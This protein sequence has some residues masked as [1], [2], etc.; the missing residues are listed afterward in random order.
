MAPAPSFYVQSHPMN[1]K[2][3]FALL[4][5]AV[6][7]LLL[8]IASADTAS[9]SWITK[10]RAALG[11][12]SALNAVKSVHFTGVLETTE[13]V[14]QQADPTKTED[15]PLR[16]AIDIVFQKPY[17]QRISLRNDKVVE[18]TALDDYDAWAKRSEAGKEDQWRLTLLDTAQIK[19]L[20]ANTWENLAFYRGLESRGGR[21]EFQGDATMDGK[22]CV[23]IVFVHSEAI[24]FTRYFEKATG[25]LIKTVT[26]NGAEI[27]EEG[28]IMVDGVRYPKK[29][30]NKSPTGQITVITFDTVKVNEAIPASE[31]AVPPMMAN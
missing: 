18:T 20:R 2:V 12:E 23:K 10:A 29:L 4:L 28:E 30:I 26:E 17:Q 7:V 5:G 14:P 21:V 6:S 27:R 8:P 11:S 24:S 13:K 19:R 22:D 25:L 3:R 16:L 31:F 9:D 15:N 1:V